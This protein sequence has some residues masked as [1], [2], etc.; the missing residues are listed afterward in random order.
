MVLFMVGM[1]LG[2]GRLIEFR[3]IHPAGNAIEPGKR[4]PYCRQP[5]FSNDIIGITKG[6][7]FTL[8]GLYPC[9]AGIRSALAF[10]RTDD[11]KIP[12]SPGIL[13]HDCDS[14]VIGPVIDDDH[15]PRLRPHLTG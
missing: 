4:G 7:R 14:V 8:G 3:K 2:Q 11:P 1:L 5:P 13:L 10:E 15:F 12:Y 9:I 6:N